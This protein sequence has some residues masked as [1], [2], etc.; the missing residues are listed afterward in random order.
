MYAESTIPSYATARPSTDI[1][2]AAHQVLTRIFWEEHRHLYDL[3][4]SEYVLEECGRGDH[5]A[6]RKRMDLVA[7]ITILPKTAEIEALAAV[8]QKLL[9]VSNRAK[10]DCNHLATCVI[11]RTDFGRRRSQRRT[12][13]LRP[14]KEEA[15]EILH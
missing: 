11:R 7:G 12:V 3:Y 2:A 6:A 8:Y 5:E 4:V 15:Y 1:I 13:L 14:C 10:T 9:D